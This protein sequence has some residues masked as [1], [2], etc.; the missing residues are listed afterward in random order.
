MNGF[1][2]G[3]QIFNPSEF[4]P[5]EVNHIQGI[6]DRTPGLSGSLVTQ[7]PIYGQVGSHGDECGRI[8]QIDIMRPIHPF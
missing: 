5:R 2:N 7:I 8:G 1:G 4:V 3:Q 6:L